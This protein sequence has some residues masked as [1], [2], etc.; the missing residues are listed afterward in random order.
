MRGFSKVRCIGLAA[1]V[2][3][4]VLGFT[5]FPSPSAT[6]QTAEANP[7]L[8]RV[9]ECVANTGHVLV[10]LLMD[11]SG[12]L[13]QTDP[14]N[15]RVTA[16]ASAIE[17]LAGL[18]E[19]PIDGKNPIVDVAV[20]GF[21]VAYEEV[22]PWTP[23]SYKNVDEVRG[24]LDQFATR[25]NGLDTDYVSALQGGRKSLAD[26]VAAAKA[27]E[28]PCRVL[29]WFTDGKFDVEDRSTA[30]RRENGTFKSWAPEINLTTKGSGQ[31]AVAAGRDLLCKAT[32]EADQL[33]GDLVTTVAIALTTQLEPQDQGFLQAL[34]TG[35]AG[36]E[37]CGAQPG[38]KLGFYAPVNDMSELIASFD[39]IANV[40]GYGTQGKPESGIAPGTNR[41]FPVDTGMSRFH[42]QVQTGAKDR[43]VTVNPVGGS[44]LQFKP[45]GT[46]NAD[47]NRGKIRYAWLSPD[48]VSVDI[49]LPP[50]PYDWAGAWSISLGSGGGDKPGGFR[51]FYYGDLTG[52]LAAGSKVSRK[53]DSDVRIQLTDGVTKAAPTKEFLDAVKIE[54]IATVDNGNGPQTIKLD[55][56]EAGGVFAGTFKPDRDGVGDTAG[57]AMDLSVM[58]KSGFA[59]HPTKSTFKAE[60][61]VE[62]TSTGGTVPAAA[63]PTK[64]SSTTKYLKF[65]GAGVGALALLGLLAF[66]FRKL[67]KR[68]AKLPAYGD[69][70]SLVLPVRIRTDDLGRPS[71]TI[72]E[73]SGSERPLSF[74]VESFTEALPDKKLPSITQGGF[75]IK[76]SGDGAAIEHPGMFVLSSV[77]NDAPGPAV[78]APLSLAPGW[79]FA[80]R[81]ALSNQGAKPSSGGLG[82]QNPKR[83]YG[84]TKTVQVENDEW[85]PTRPDQANAGGPT[86]APWGDSPPKDR[87]R[88]VGFDGP[89]DGGSFD[90]MARPYVEGFLLI[91]LRDPT[92]LEAIDHSVRYVL[93]NRANQI[94]GRMG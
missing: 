65:G 2:A 21:A 67:G 84:R 26:R 83:T 76:P 70:R 33:R 42:F 61:D 16:A 89:P 66:G 23:I 81:Q 41:A 60:F 93:P 56:P 38:D 80:G 59:L 48:V 18:A 71:L 57:I 1:L 17:S 88:T 27:T 64:P 68:G 75:Q 62:G 12:S 69:V 90:Q 87:G 77:N 55:R 49:D 85:S 11:E 63:Q 25:N 15:E 50:P 31:T 79:Y 47:F 44:P 14:K 29:M 13:K 35:T 92:E 22:I 46:N 28:T 10:L 43:S 6:A 3:V 30:K 36:T 53:G 20:A 40:L 5:P 86:T 4:S 82:A 19:H 74:S 52:A 7:A 8:L 39:A 32:G 37:K 45:T 72:V 54:A 78:L 73:P 9:S 34:A 24:K 91:L 94:L 51:I 58:T